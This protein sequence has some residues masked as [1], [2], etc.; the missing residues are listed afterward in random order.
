M[1]AILVLYFVAVFTGW[2]V[3]EWDRGFGQP[4]FL[5]LATVATVGGVLRGHLLFARRAHSEPRFRRELDRYATVLMI[6]DV[7]IAATLVVEGWWAA[8]T[9]PVPGALTIALGVAIGLARLVLERSTT[10][11]AFPRPGDAPVPQEAR[12]PKPGAR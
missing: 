7:I 6:T 9:R 4:G 5:L 8:A 11:A 10:E 3:K 1:L 12:S 2:L